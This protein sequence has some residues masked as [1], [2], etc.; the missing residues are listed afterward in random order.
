MD[1]CQQLDRIEHQ[2]IQV[3]LS[4]TGIVNDARITP[5][6]CYLPSKK[7][8]LHFNKYIISNKKA[9]VTQ[10]I[11]V[12]NTLIATEANCGV[13]R[14]L[15]AKGCEDTIDIVLPLISALAS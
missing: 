2:V 15:P 7:D 6:A 5:L 1:V 9:V 14:T 10:L 4:K 8:V 13:W 3:T 11:Y 12:I